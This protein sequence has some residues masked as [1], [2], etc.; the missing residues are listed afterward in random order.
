MHKELK[1]EVA[2]PPSSN[3]IWQQRRLNRFV[4]E[5]NY[6]RPHKALGNLTPS[7]IYTT[8][9]RA[10]PSKIIPWEYSKEFTVRRVY[11]NGCIRWG[12]DNW[13]MVATPLI[14]KEIGMEKLGNG[15]GRVFFRQKLLGY[16]DE[17]ILRIKDIERRTKFTGN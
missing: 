12:Y 3:R 16:L 6:E 10:Y 7:K 14:D 15:I 13:I 17:K 11:R 4:H 1:A 2:R 8:S 9:V 5:Y